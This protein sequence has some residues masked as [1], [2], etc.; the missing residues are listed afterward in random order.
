MQNKNTIFYLIEL[1]RIKDR[2]NGTDYFQ[3]IYSNGVDEIIKPYL[4]GQTI[5][6]VIYD[7]EN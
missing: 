5:I 6:T 4:Y 3:A 7:N 1:N 2:S